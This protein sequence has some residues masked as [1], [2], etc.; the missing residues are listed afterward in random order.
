MKNLQQQI[1]EKIEQATDILKKFG[2][3]SAQLNDRTAYCLLAL[4]NVTPEK[5]WENIENHMIGITPMM[6]FTK[7][8]YLKEYAPNSRETFRRFSVHQLVQAGIVL[9]NPD[10]F[11]RPVN[12]PKAVYQ[13]SP[14]AFDVIKTYGTKDFESKIQDFLKNQK[15]LSKQYAHERE[16]NMVSVQI[17]DEHSIQISPGKHSELIKDIIEQL[18]PRFLPNSTLVYIGDTGEKWGYYDQEIAGNLLFN[19][20]EHGK[21]PDVILYVE[22]KNWLAL[23]ESVTS[24]G[25]VDSKR[26]IELKDLF[27]NVN[28]DLVFISAFPDRSTFVRF[29]HDIAWETE[30][31]IA[32]NPDH[33]I[34]FNGDKFIGPHK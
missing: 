17:K 7:T 16:I 25:P 8:N 15:S 4:L 9:Y 29:A 30:A 10:D 13:I 18:A 5:S 20:L 2:M 23:V 22:D 6:D 31:W 24:H 11:S 21:M 14:A 34:H 12:S 32:D 3:P 26:Y 1:S 27:S 28:A 33:M 19:V